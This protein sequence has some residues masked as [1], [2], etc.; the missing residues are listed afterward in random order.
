MRGRRRPQ[1]EGF[2]RLEGQVAR[3]SCHVEHLCSEA[4]EVLFVRLDHELGNAL[5]LGRGVEHLAPL[6]H[7]LGPLRAKRDGHPEMVV[8]YVLEDDALRRNDFDEDAL[9]RV[10]RTVR[11]V[12]DEGAK[13][14]PGAGR[15][16]ELCW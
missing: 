12:H 13:C 3:G 10:V 2:A 15:T 11:P 6:N 14:H 9:V 5:P 1:A 4:I 16:R 8:R 7:C